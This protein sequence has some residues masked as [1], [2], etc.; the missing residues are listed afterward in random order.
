MKTAIS[1][2][3]YWTALMAIL[4]YISQ[5]SRLIMS[6][7]LW[8][9]EFQHARLPCPSSTPR[10]CSNS[11]PSNKWCHPTI[12]FSVIPFSSCLQSFPASRVF[13]S[14]SV[15]HIRLPKYWSF[16]FSNHPSNENSGLISLGLTG[17]ISLQSKELSRVFSNITVQNHQFFGVQLSLWS[18]SH[19]HTWLLEKPQ[20]WLCI[21]I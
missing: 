8:P 19:I 3:C 21:Y 14:E 16:S 4:I 15:L 5:F 6:D 2:F 7:S 10:A 12:S 9:H 18:N 20:L 13:S 17:W 1:S 11:C